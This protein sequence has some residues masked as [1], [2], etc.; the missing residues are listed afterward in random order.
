VEAPN[1]TDNAEIVAWVCF[2]LGALLVLL[3]LLIG[4]VLSFRKVATDV[5]AKVADAS[6][7]VDQLT[8]VAV[9]SAL[10]D[11]AN[12]SAADDAEDKAEEV[13][14]KLGE[15]G[16]LVGSL[17]EHLRFAGLLILVGTVLMSVATVQFGGQQI[18]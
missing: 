3:G 2:G 11:S 14:S 5:K 10:T 9:T 12:Q 17:P 16:S 6:A 18:F 7:T 4:L 1:L 13:K 8:T 15:I